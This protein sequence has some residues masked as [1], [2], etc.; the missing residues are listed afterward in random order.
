MSAAPIRSPAALAVRLA[1]TWWRQLLALA[2]ACA[3]VAATIAGAVGVGDALQ[4]GLRR[5]ALERL[6]GVTAAVVGDR[7]FRAD[8]VRSAEGDAPLHPALV[9]EVTFEAAAG[10]VPARATIL[11]CDAAADLGF[12][13]APPPVAGGEV[14]LNAPLAEALGVRAGDTVVV[15]VPMPSAIPADSPMG[16]RTPES[17]GRRLRVAAIL[18]ERGIGRFSLRPAQ[19][20]TGV[21][22]A[23]LG[24]LQDIL[25]RGDVA[26][27]GLAVGPDAATLKAR[28][29]PALADVGLALEPVPE[30]GLRLSSAALVLPAEVDRVAEEVLRPEGGVPTLVF[31]ANA[32]TAPPD[33]GRPAARIPYSTVLGIADG[34]LPVGALEDADGRPLTPP[35]DDG[36]VIDRWMADDLAAQG[37]PVAV[38]DPLEVRLFLPETLHGHV[39]ERVE[40][41][42]VTGIA[43]MEGMALARSVVPEV[44]GFT[45]EKSIADWDP[46]F[47]FDRQAVRTV[48]PHDEDDR[49]WK[50][51]GATPKAFVSLRC[52]RRLAA[53]RFGATTAW[54]LPG[55]DPGARDGLAARLAAGLV[56][57]RLGIRVDDLRANALEAARGSTPFGSLFLALSSFVVLSG[58]LLEWL[59]FQLLVAARRRDVGVLSAIGWSPRGIGRLLALVGGVAAAVGVVVGTAAGPAWA[60]LLLRFLAA[61]WNQSV[62]AGSAA[63]FG[64]GAVRWAGLWPGALA[65]AVLS[66]AAIASAAW[67][68]ARRPPL[69]LLRGGAETA[70]RLPAARRGAA[71]LAAAALVA[72]AA[73]AWM[74]GNADAQAAVGLFFLAGALALVGLL[75]LVRRWL[76][77]AAIGH[78]LDSLGRL[79]WRG[80]AHRP[81]RAFT[82]AAIVAV[83]EFLIVAVSAFS[84]APPA[85]PRDRAGPTGGWTTI[86]SFSSP[87]SVDPSDREALD[88]LGLDAVDRDLL[89][90][91]GVARLRASAGDDASCTNLYAASRPVVLGVGPGFVD[92]GGFRFT[93]HLPLPADAADPW[94]LLGRGPDAPIAA[95]LDDAT[96]RW[97]LKYGG[98]GSRFT[99]PDEE[100]V[101]VEF[102]I[103]GLLEPG[104]LQ[105]WVIVAERDFERLFPSRSGYSMALV[106]AGDADPGA[107]ERAVRGAWVDAGVTTEPAL[108]RLRRLSAVQNTFL[109]AFQALGT[110]G[111]LLGTAGVAA[112]QVQGVLERVGTFGLLA[113][114]GFPGRSSRAVVVLETLFMVG[115]GLAVGAV[116]GAVTLPAHVA[117]GRASVPV[118]WILVTAALSLAV[119]L[120]AGLA[121]TRA[122]ARLT[123]R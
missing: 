84:L 2:A 57:E 76:A 74:A 31:L 79:A 85:R 97:A 83:A 29:R 37:R 18:P 109:A 119:A 102:E 10:G 103:V 14:A 80:L 46:P 112:V 107:V 15:R 32:L 52:A 98:V 88:A 3:V 53:G 56:P 39:E 58:L 5:L 68:A 105:G 13:P 11:A 50:A 12:S 7:F 65:A 115:L 78:I 6:G 114:L 106:D 71:V 43:R 93:G 42:R 92:R 72:A 54:F 111:L 36:I 82:V 21:A 34:V 95:I 48:P 86:A 66:M 49:Y 96:A 123:P 89:A 26:N 122:V 51:H 101:A 16:R 70:A 62:A 118:G 17:A 75:A 22:V 77:R 113:A 104:I 63:V 61:T 45:D 41:L 40:R 81:Q 59:L 90:G 28:L 69:G 30:G 20:T 110:L 100:G 108:E 1:A 35:P 44:E 91:A 27:A 25:R 120:L 24:T 47:P 19:L 9:L 38:G 8:L 67:S 73:A 33:A 23:R 4:T 55:M 99:L 87:S 64:E 60:R 117:G 116:A 94:R 121:A